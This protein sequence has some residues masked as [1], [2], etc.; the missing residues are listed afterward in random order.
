MD[1]VPS[2]CGTGTGIS[3]PARKLALCPDSAT[4]DGSANT[5]ARL[6]PSMRL[7]SAKSPWLAEFSTRLK[8]DAIGALVCARKLD[9]APP[10]NELSAVGARVERVS[11]G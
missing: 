9:V 7:K 4:S 6:L 8:A 3:P 10:V 11:A 5:L 1:V 2:A